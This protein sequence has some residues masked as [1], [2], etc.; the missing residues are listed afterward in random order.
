MVVEQEELQLLQRVLLDHKVQLQLFQQYRPQVEDMEEVVQHYNQVVL[1]DQ[2]GPAVEVEMVLHQDQQVVM[3]MI[4]QLIPFKEL[5]EAKVHIQVHQVI[6]VQVA[7]AEQFVQVQIILQ[8]I[9][10]VVME[11]QVLQLL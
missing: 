8:L 7:E 2:V 11:E 4:P 6:M 3:E 1:G 5:M 9:P 10:M